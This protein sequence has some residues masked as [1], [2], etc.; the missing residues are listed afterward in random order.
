MYKANFKFAI[1]DMDGTLLDTMYAHRTSVVQYL[2]NYGLEELADE[3]QEEYLYISNSKALREVAPYCEQ[4]GIP[5]PTIDDLYKIM[6]KTYEAPPVKPNVKQFLENLRNQ[7][8]RM[9][10]V[11]SNAQASA[12]FA[13]KNAGLD[14]YFEFILTDEVYPKGKHD[15]E[16]FEAA[17]ERFRAKPEET[18]VFEDALYSIRTAKQMNM[19]TVGLSDPFNVKN[20]DKIKELVDE[21]FDVLPI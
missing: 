15:T 11:S 9:C 3:L 17:L 13:L 19:Q 21:Y 20:R 2:R 8:V 14:S 7:N 5:A 1:F 4:Y 16:I 10:V 18:A 12:E 6:L